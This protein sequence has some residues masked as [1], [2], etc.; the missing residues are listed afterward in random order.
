MLVIET[1][2]ADAEEVVVAVYATPGYEPPADERAGWVRELYP[3]AHVLVLPDPEPEG[4]PDAVS[5]EYAEHFR[6][7]YPGE[8][9]H[10]YTSEDY[11]PRFARYLGAEH[12]AV[13]P[14][15]RRVPVSATEIRADP[16]EH[17]RF[18]EPL[19]YRS[20]VMKV[21]L[22]GAESTGKTT[23]AAALADHYATVWMPEYGRELFEQKKGKLEFDD[24]YEIA[25][26][27]LRRENELAAQARR[28]LFCD[29]NALAT[30]FWSE[31]Y[32]GRCD[33]RL[34]QLAQEVEKDYVYVL[35]GDDI[36][37]FQ[38][39]WRETGGGEFWREH[40]RVIRGDLERRG[41]P[42]V[43]AIGTL[44]ER[45]KR[46]ADWLEEIRPVA[47]PEPRS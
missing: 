33:P 22:V 30:E 42:Y 9:T 17:R 43:E 36:S 34:I 31:F 25:K 29:T 6:R 28:F 3:D 40:Q 15:R 38:D 47:N 45:V 46:V 37:W 5:R 14:E 12:V 39:G 10:V 27:H 8:I 11:G 23:L 32:F 21:C 1:A 35:C 7:H 2:L 24:L 26:E 20:L 41:L 18:L 13:D 44:D 16:F 19:V 4:D